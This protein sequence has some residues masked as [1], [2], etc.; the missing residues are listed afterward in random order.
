M[1]ENQLR[2][3]LEQQE[4]SSAEIEEVLAAYRQTEDKTT[5]P[6]VVA[7]SLR[8]MLELEAMREVDWRKRAAL[9][10]KII[11]LELE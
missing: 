10:A 5:P 8:Q 6:A 4:I 9:M 3:V 11:S 1:D 7:Q 2:I